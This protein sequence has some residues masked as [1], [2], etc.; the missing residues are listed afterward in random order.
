MAAARAVAAHQGANLRAVRGAVLVERPDHED[1]LIELGWG[2]PFAS[3]FA[4]MAT[5]GRIPA[6]VTVEHRNRYV[7]LGAEGELK[8]KLSGR[9]RLQLEQEGLLPVVGDWVILQP[10]QSGGIIERTLPRRS[11]FSRKVAG[12]ATEEQVMAANIDTIFLASALPD[13]LNLRRLERYLLLT[14]ESGAKPVILLTKSDLSTDVN[15][16]IEQMR[17][18]AL[19]VP[20]HVIS[21]LRREGLDALEPYL[22]P[23]TT[24]AVLGSSGVGKSTLINALLGTERLRTA[25]VR[26]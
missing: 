4:Q 24:I 3:A 23:G 13:D 19:G 20:I 22:I 8:A 9:S 25:E 2:E 11:R 17:S 15:A 6:R 14:A 12:R 26:D 5:P 7:L 21:S 18:T 16:A 10:R 1:K